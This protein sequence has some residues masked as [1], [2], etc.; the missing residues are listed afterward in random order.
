M[1]LESWQDRWMREGGAAEMHLYS[2]LYLHPCILRPGA[3][4]VICGD[5]VCVTHIPAPG[6][7]R[8]AFCSLLTVP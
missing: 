6:E 1:I 7:C 4:M 2:H 5:F 3:E 8:E